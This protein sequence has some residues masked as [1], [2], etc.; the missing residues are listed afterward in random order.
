MM[1]ANYRHIG[2]RE[3]RLG[4]HYSRFWVFLPMPS[5]ADQSLALRNLQNAASNRRSRD[6]EAT[7]ARAASNEHPEQVKPTIV[8]P[9]KRAG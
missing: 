2:S 3:N 1:A 6:K 9:F 5:F 7:A 4:R 8:L